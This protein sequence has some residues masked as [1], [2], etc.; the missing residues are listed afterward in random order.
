[1][2]IGVIGLAA[3]L[4]A[5]VLASPAAGA[6]H[7]LKI[8]EVYPGSTT[9][10]PGA[11]FVE[12]QL[13]V[14]GENQVGGG[15]AQVDIYNALGADVGGTPFLVDPPNGQAQRTILVA[16]ATAQAAF[17]VTPDQALPAGDSI[18]A[19]GTACLNSTLFADSI[20]CVSWGAAAAPPNTSPAGTPAPAIADGASIARSIVRGCATLLDGPDDTND[21]AADFI[22]SA[23]SP[24]PNDVT[25]TETECGNGPGDD[26]EAPNTEITKA[27][28]K[29][30]AK[31]RARFEFRS[32]E[33]GST[34]QCKLDKGVFANCSSPFQKKVKVG[35]H[36][37]EVRA[38]D[39]AGNTDASPASVKF[40]RT[41]KR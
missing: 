32:S 24:R 13:P 19:A 18:G 1:M 37:F 31:K 3:G 22:Q 17:G 7:L 20:D 33:A 15:T 6:H 11:E 16:T 28:K 25:P 10:G 39:S 38:T 2:R 21:S 8:S 36:R 34:F 9:H 41:A 5:L 35:K 14:A 27:P 29:K 23:P 26:T 4:A 40:R 30:S 12:L